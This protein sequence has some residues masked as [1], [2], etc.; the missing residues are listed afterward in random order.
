MY[1]YFSNEKQNLSLQESLNASHIDPKEALPNT[2]NLF[3]LQKPAHV[4]RIHDSAFW[5]VPQC[6]AKS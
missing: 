5:V 2:K 4:P 3:S 1:Y 6:R